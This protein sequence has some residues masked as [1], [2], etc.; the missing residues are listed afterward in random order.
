MDMQAQHVPRKEEQQQ[1]AQPSQQS[2][3]DSKERDQN[4]QKQPAKPHQSVNKLHQVQKAHDK[5]DHQDESEQ[6]NHQLQENLEVQRDKSDSHLHR[7]L[8]SKQIV[9]PR[10]PNDSPYR[11]EDSI[12]PAQHEGNIQKFAKNQKTLGNRGKGEI[13]QRQQEQMDPEKKRIQK[14]KQAQHNALDMQ[15]TTVRDAESN[16]QGQQAQRNTEIKKKKKKEKEKPLAGQSDRQA[17][18][19]VQDDRTGLHQQEQQKEEHADAQQGHNTDMHLNEERNNEDDQ[20]EP[21][22]CQQESQGS[23]LDDHSQESQQIVDKERKQEPHLDNEG[24]NPEESIEPN[25][26]SQSK[27][28]ELQPQRRSKRRSQPPQRLQIEQPIEKRPRASRN[29][30]SADKGKTLA[31][32]QRKKAPNKVDDDTKDM[33]V[34]N[35]QTTCEPVHPMTYPAYNHL[36]AHLYP[37]PPPCYPPPPFALFG[38]PTAYIS[39]PNQAPQQ[40]NPSF[41]PPPPPLRSNSNSA[42]VPSAPSNFASS[43]AAAAP[44]PPPS[45]TPPPPPSS[46]PARAFQDPHAV[47]LRPM[48]RREALDY[49][50][51]VKTA[52][53]SQPDVFNRFLSLLKA[54]SN[55]S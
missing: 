12:P 42:M 21:K 26:E 3:R 17:Q 7:E 37:P 45:P 32:T 22:Q 1:S 30:Q 11:Q 49:I 5:P 31:K 27:P 29:K 35:D 23:V 40:I 8:Q 54:N 18:K 46:Q 2:L 51:S 6:H 19:D 38:P 36:Y 14:R 10:K 20:Q 33:H 43:S 34:N 16:E 25:W 55:K 4:M 47:N 15:S 52:F 53:A 41:L 13:V 39:A 44:A 48:S 50:Q 28:H 24:Q 9:Q